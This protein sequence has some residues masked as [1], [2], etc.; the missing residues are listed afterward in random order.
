MAQAIQ[1]SCLNEEQAK[2]TLNNIC[3][4]RGENPPRLISNA[5]P[6]YSQE[7][8]KKFGIIYITKFAQKYETYLSENG[9][10]GEENHGYII[11]YND[12][13]DTYN[14]SA[15]AAL[16]IEHLRG[17][18]DEKA[19][20]P[21][22]DI[23]CA[24]NVNE[25]LR[26]HYKNDILP[27]CNYRVWSLCEVYMML[28]SKTDVFKLTYDYKKLK[29]EENYAH[30]EYLKIRD[31]DPMV[32]ALNAVPG[33]LITCKYLAYDDG[34]FAS[35]TIKQ[36]EKYIINIHTIDAS[37]IVIRNPGEYGESLTDLDA[38]SWSDSDNSAASNSPR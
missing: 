21:K 22:M 16:Y 19:Y 13:V 28:G 17:K 32:K 23:L 30:L 31:S 33:D 15:S 10:N 24:F 27:A 34:V 4:I 36:V 9:K 5:K 2:T 26:T 6:K 11:I 29:F 38:K 25:N 18:I 8:C 3:A 37:G 14:I 7:M 20:P 1:V 12:K 35:T